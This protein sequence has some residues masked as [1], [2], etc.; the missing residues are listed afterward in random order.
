VEVSSLSNLRSIYTPTRLRI[1]QCAF[2]TTA[3]ARLVSSMQDLRLTSVVKAQLR[4]VLLELW[5]SGTCSTIRLLRDAYKSLVGEP[6][7]V[8][9]LRG[10]ECR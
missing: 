7:G 2:R 1:K 6:E 5:M 4:L 10:I 3:L 9:P 8:R